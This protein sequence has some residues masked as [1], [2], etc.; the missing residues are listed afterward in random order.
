MSGEVT[1]IES[2]TDVIGEL[3]ESIY[4][5]LLRSV[6]HPVDDGVQIGTLGVETVTEMRS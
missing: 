3:H 4:V 5:S 1:G 6:V 2:E